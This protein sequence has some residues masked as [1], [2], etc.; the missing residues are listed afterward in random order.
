MRI[1]L[2]RICLAGTVKGL[3]SRLSKEAEGTS[4]ISRRKLSAFRSAVWVVRSWVSGCGLVGRGGGCSVG[5]V[6][7]TFVAFLNI[8][9]LITL[10]NFFLLAPPSSVVV[11]R[12]RTARIHV[13]KGIP[14][15][16]RTCHFDRNSGIGINS[17]LIFLSAPRILTGLRRTRTMHHTTRTR[18]TGT[19]GNTHTRRVTKTCRV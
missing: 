18:G 11:K 16:V 17:A 6:L 13:S 12:T 8:I 15:Q 3:K 10:A 4:W 5:G 14:K 2:A 7:L 1:G 19:V 9:K